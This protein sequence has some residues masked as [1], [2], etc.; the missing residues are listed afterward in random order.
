MEEAFAER[1]GRASP[2]SSARPLPL[3]PPLPF[4]LCIASSSSSTLDC[5]IPHLANLYPRPLQLC[6]SST[7]VSQK[8]GTRRALAGF[9]ANAVLQ[10]SSLLHDP[11]LHLRPDIAIS[12]LVHAHPHCAAGTSARVLRTSIAAGTHLV[13]RAASAQS[14]RPATRSS[15]S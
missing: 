10:E 8:G 5:A 2:T 4:V 15:T 14:H 6:A 13:P 12:P 3:A 1:G 9:S 11:S 7:G